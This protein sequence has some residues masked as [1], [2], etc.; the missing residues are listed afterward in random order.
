MMNWA[1]DKIP[2]DIEDQ[3]LRFLF[4]DFTMIFNQQ[5]K[6]DAVNVNGGLSLTTIYIDG[7]WI[8]KPS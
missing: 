6:L 5:I 3:T 7:T 8:V 1:F 2:I 4:S